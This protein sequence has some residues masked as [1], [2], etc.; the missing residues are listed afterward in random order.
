MLNALKSAI[1]YYIS[2]KLSFITQWNINFTVLQSCLD[3]LI[4]E[5]CGQLI[6]NPAFQL[7]GA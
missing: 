2:L 1:F 4:L 3:P 5:N 7:K 6:D